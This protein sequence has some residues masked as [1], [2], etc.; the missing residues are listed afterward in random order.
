MTN[1]GQDLAADKGGRI[2]ELDG[3]RGTAILLV[4]IWHSGVIRYVPDNT[5][6]LLL[7]L[8]VPLLYTWSGVDLFFVLSGFL[9]GGILL[10]N[11][12]AT[13]YFRVF[14]IRRT[15]RIFPLYYAWLLIFL[16]LP[17]IAPFLTAASPLL[18]KD[19]LPL[20]S[21]ATYTQNFA[22]AGR[23]SLGAGWLGVTWSLAIEEQFYL[24]LPA[25]VRALRPARLPIFLLAV[26]VLAPTLRMILPLS[27]FF[28][29]AYFANTILTPCRVD[30]LFMGAFCAYAIRRKSA[31]EFLQRHASLLRGSLLISL[32]P[33]MRVDL[34]P[35]GVRMSM[36]LTF[37]AIAYSLLLLVVVS[38]QNGLLAWVMRM[39]WLRSL[40]KIAYGVYLF[41]LG[42]AYLVHGVILGTPPRTQTWT[43]LVVTL[44]ALAVT[45][46]IAQLSWILF[47]RPILSLGHLFIYKV[48]ATFSDELGETGPDHPGPPA[49]A[50]RGS[51]GQAGSPGAHPRDESDCGG[52]SIRGQG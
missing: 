13:N 34:F 30:A 25:L 18:F 31:A 9:I 51:P 35:V 3:I 17:V 39:P 28:Q 4:L 38:N 26:I 12:E 42:I 2:P 49:G 10:D 24:I 48:E 16:A 19:P 47:E 36:N 15:C 14:Y 11:R 29:N 33:L 40:G 27:G 52:A 37:L 6:P 20:L 23:G 50:D 43:D 44:L 1:T 32:L 21:Y 45:I 5:S 7:L 41:H 22:M 46:A 8:R